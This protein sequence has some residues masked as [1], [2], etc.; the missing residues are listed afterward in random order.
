MARA[1][2]I[3]LDA[4]TTYRGG[5]TGSRHDGAD[6][7]DTEAF[8]AFE[9]IR[10]K[11]EEDA[12]ASDWESMSAR[13]QR[14]ALETRAG[15]WFAERFGMPWQAE[16][17]RLARPGTHPNGSNTSGP[18]RKL[19]RRG[20]LVARLDWS[21]FVPWQREPTGAARFLSALEYT[22]VSILAGNLTGRWRRRP[23]PVEVLAG[24][25][26][27]MRKALIRYGQ[28]ELIVGECVGFSGPHNDPVWRRAP[29]QMHEKPLRPRTPKGSSP[30]FRVRGT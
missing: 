17:K 10:L 28:R 1:K 5:G 18:R 26:V 27:L 21:I 30:R 3:P 16:W 19:S 6:A 24:E 4:P 7:E 15:E 25:L 9:S 14:A 13:A 2:E 11:N 22:F 8:A 29:R 23:S 12:N 20:S